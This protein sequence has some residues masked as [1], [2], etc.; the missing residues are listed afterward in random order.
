MHDL[1]LHQRHFREAC[2]GVQAKA[3]LICDR[4]SRYPDTIGPFVYVVLKDLDTQVQKLQHAGKPTYL[5]TS[6]G[7]V[8]TS[9]PKGTLCIM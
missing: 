5:L 9:L 8:G 2:R 1:D 4:R 6:L 3:R 7:M